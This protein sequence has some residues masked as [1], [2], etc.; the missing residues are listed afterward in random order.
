[1][2]FTLLLFDSFV[3]ARSC[4]V[5]VCFACGASVCAILI[6]TCHACFRGHVL[7]LVYNYVSRLPYV[8]RSPY[9]VVPPAAIGQRGVEL[10]ITLGHGS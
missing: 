7:F 10:F 3:F 4:G 6:T 1:M 8:L 2:L 9:T 5:D